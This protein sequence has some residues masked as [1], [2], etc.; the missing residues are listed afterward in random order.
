M[1]Q[2][3][4]RVPATGL[5][6]TCAL[7]GV[8]VWLFRAPAPGA[9]TAGA[10][11]AAAPEPAVVEVAAAIDA[12]LA[13]TVS[14]PGSVASLQDARIASE[15]GGRVAWAA[16]PGFRLVRGEVAARLDDEA[17]RLLATQHEAALLRI[18]TSLALARR[19]AD[20]LAAVAE[21]S[22][23]SISA[24]QLD[25]VR[26][27]RDTLEQD[28]RIAEATLAETRRRIGAATIRAP[29]DGVVVERFAQ[30]GEHLAPGSPVLRLLDTDRLEVLA[31][32][33][34]EVA[35]MLREGTTVRL[36]AGTRSA[37]G[38]V[39][40]VVP[41]GEGAARQTSV[42]IA[43]DA[44]PWLAGTAVSV[45]LPQAPARMAVMAPRD[46]LVL[47]GLDR[48]VF[49]VREAR[50]ERIAVAPG[51]AQGDAV[52]VGAPIQAGDL[53]VVRGAERL[54]DGQTVVVADQSRG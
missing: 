17:L 21:S 35:A 22:Q 46:A 6:L 18:D 10:A 1:K 50:A 51:S 29:F 45:A 23:S 41:V 15:L 47:R 38:Q 28:R 7:A 32:A 20:R 53:L 37:D 12:T 4:R 44:S 31:T 33:P 3:T 26:A 43:L 30:P 40:A 42:R 2:F 34:L 16:E 11:V 48:F 8:G 9:A 54:V 49:R 5:L 36:A 39:R 25:Q 13:P 19:Q 27:E 52:E 14:V 24:A